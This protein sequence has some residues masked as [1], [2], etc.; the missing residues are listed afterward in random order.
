MALALN[1]FKTVATT[2]SDNPTIYYSAPVGYSGV[3][4][5]SQVT[6]IGNDTQFLSVWHKRFSGAEIDIQMLR[7]YPIPSNETLNLF[8]GK[9]IM[10]S[11]DSLMIQGTQGSDLNL[12]LSILETL[13]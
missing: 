2:L 12:I 5:L 13:N 9:L 4:L 3:V 7:Q 6:N 10:E 11:G 1:I 8:T